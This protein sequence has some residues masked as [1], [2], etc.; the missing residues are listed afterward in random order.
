MSNTSK[1]TALIAP[2]EP[3]DAFAPLLSAAA[4]VA[5]GRPWWLKALEAV[6]ASL[7]ASITLLLFTGVLSRYLFSHP[8]VWLDE[9]VSLQFLWLA[10]IG[11]IIAVYRNEHLRLSV[12]VERLPGPLREYVHAFALVAMAAVLLALVEPSFTYAQ[13]EWFIRT[14]AMDIPN[15]FRVSAW[16]SAWWGCWCWC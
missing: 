15:T 14:P 6:A 12:F 7:A 1:G 9:L 5:S 13:E 2:A 10:M 8:I 3:V 4:D 11:A 16:P